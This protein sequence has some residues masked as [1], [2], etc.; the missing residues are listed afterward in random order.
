MTFEEVYEKALKF[1]SEF[2]VS[3]QA[4]GEATKMCHLLLQEFKCISSWNNSEHF[5]RFVEI[6]VE[7][8]KNSGVPGYSHIN[9]EVIQSVSKDAFDNELGVSNFDSNWKEKPYF[10]AYDIDGDLS[11]FKKLSRN[12][13]KYI[14]ITPDGVIHYENKLDEEEIKEFTFQ[15]AKKCKEEIEEI[16][17][18]ASESE[19]KDLKKYLTK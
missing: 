1:D 11:F 15:D 4:F 3:E 18:M 5:R 2:K 9:S 17:D 12:R 19:L 7:M 13:W 10:I 6:R 16:L 14:Y 8:M